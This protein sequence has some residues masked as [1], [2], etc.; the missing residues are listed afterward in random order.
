MVGKQREKR[1][2]YT[3]GGTRTWTKTSIGKGE[4]VIVQPEKETSEIKKGK[5]DPT[6]K[7]LA[8]NWARGR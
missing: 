3:Y 7:S 2:Q 1:E 6:T 4:I 8:K 5:I